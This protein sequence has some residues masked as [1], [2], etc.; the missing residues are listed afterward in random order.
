M[1]IATREARARVPSR[2]AARLDRP[3]GRPRSR[4]RRA[5]RS[6]SAPTSRSASSPAAI[7]RN[8]QVSPRPGWY[9]PTNL[10]V[11]VAL[12]PGQRKTPVFKAALRP[13]RT[14]ERQRMRDW[15]EQERL[16]EIS[17]A[18]FEKRRKELVSE[19]A[20]DDELDPERLAA[21]MDEL[22]AGLGPTEAAAA[23][24]LLTED[25]T[26]EGLAGLLA[27]A[28]PDHRRLRR[29]RRAVREPRRPLRA[30]LDQ[31]GRV[32]QGALGASTSRSTA[33]APGR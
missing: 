18:I 2:D 23:P 9:E 26:P 28:R 25:V 31:L 32:Q 33:R 16:V 17:G 21:M 7:A 19:A 8:V 30:R 15:E 4:R 11:I 12:A 10:Y 27:G 14:L 3:T 29:G 22:L 24:R 6:T 20:G 5:P 13:V 1:P